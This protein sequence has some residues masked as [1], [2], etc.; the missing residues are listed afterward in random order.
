MDAG[1][2]VD[3][4]DPA[5]EWAGGGLERFTGLIYE[6]LFDGS[7]ALK[8]GVDMAAWRPKCLLRQLPWQSKHTQ[9]QAAP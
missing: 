2:F 7:S 8:W 6:A 3:S 1:L 9:L 4:T 5:L